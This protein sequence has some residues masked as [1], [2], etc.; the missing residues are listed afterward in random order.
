MDPI[1]ALMCYSTETSYV[2]MGLEVLAYAKSNKRFPTYILMQ[3]VWNKIKQLQAVEGFTS[4]SPIWANGHYEELSSLECGARW[5][6][7][8][9]THLK[10]I[11]V[12]G[13]M[14]FYYMQLHPGMDCHRD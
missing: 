12:D 1:R 11:F 10:H 13:K 9:V 2:A 3:K 8:G 4:Y 7:H 5:R 14:L 6:R